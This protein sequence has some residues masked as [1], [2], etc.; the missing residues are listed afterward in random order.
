MS[1]GEG[2][3]GGRAAMG[4][5]SMEDEHTAGRR[6]RRLESGQHRRRLRLINAPLAP[7]Q[8][9]AEEALAAPCW[10]PRARAGAALPPPRHVAAGQGAIRTAAP[11][12]CGAGEPLVS[13]ITSG[14]RLT[15]CALG[16]RK[17]L[18]MHIS[19]GTHALEPRDPC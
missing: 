4:S 17:P 10:M 15:L 6:S 9:G 13:N 2:F 11:A 18:L 12:A 3:C 1:S 8:M 16:L 7:A 14:L 19:A 5:S